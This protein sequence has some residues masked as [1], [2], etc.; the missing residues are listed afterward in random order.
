MNLASVLLLLSRFALAGDAAATATPPAPPPAQAQVI[1]VY[2]GD[3]FTLDTGD[4]V[5]LRAVNTPEIKPYE[6]FAS[7]ARDA[8]EAF[9]SGRAVTLRYGNT[10]RDHYGR[11]IADVEVDGESLATHL[12]ERGLAHVF[13]V[14]PA[15]QDLSALLDAQAR[16]R[17]AGLGIWSDD[18]YKGDLHITSFHANGRGDERVNVNAEYLRVCNVAGVPLDLSQFRITDISGNV[19]ELPPITVPAGY[20][21]EIRSGRGDDNGDPSRPL[22]VFLDNDY[23]IWNNDRDRAT[24]LDQDGKVVD[25]RE[26][27]PKSRNK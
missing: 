8:T 16:A 23:P 18:R 6:Q 5:R 13:V 25:S 1:S 12:A 17:G 27:A 3:T 26:H 7:E 2:D 14:A 9:V 22:Q 19:W 15:D 21:F 20:T 11:L 24:L 4:R 10:V